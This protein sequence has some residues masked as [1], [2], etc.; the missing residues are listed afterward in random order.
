MALWDLKAKAANVPAYKLLG[1]LA[2]ET[3]LPYYSGGPCLWPL[4][5]TVEMCQYYVERG[6]RAIKFSTGYYLKEGPAELPTGW[7]V[8]PVSPARVGEQEAEKLEAVRRGVG[9]EI[10]IILDGHQGGIPHPFGPADAIRVTEAVAPY[11]LL[12]FEEPLPYTNPEGYAELRRHGRVPIGGGES[13]S[14]IHEFHRFFQLE[15]LDIVQP[16]VTYSGGIGICWEVLREAATRNLRSAMHTGGTFGPG[17]AASVHLAFASTTTL[18]LEHVVSCTEAQEDIMLEPI[19][20]RNGVIGPPA[21]PGLGVEINDALLDK[22]A[23]VSGSGEV[24]SA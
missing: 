10:E 21:A 16:E 4:E 6:Y 8:R 23:Y 15:A 1:G 12:F 18:V 13:L 11:A 9:R 19:R 20:L 17:L 3:V 5:K 22:Y 7:R 24:I 2:R 14:G